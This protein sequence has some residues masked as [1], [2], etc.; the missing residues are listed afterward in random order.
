MLV[1]LE[2]GL[3]N[4]LIRF[5]RFTSGTGK[6]ISVTFSSFELDEYTSFNEL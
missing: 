2:R 6:T 1:T 4:G 3:A 5:C